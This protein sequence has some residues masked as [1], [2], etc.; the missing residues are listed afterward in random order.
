M[1]ARRRKRRL[2]DPV[3]RYGGALTPSDLR[4]GLWLSAA[5]A[6]VVLGPLVWVQG[7]ILWSISSAAPGTTI[8]SIWVGL[9]GTFGFGVVVSLSAW[10][11]FSWLV[12]RLRARHASRPASP[13]TLVLFTAPP[14]RWPWAVFAVLFLPGVFSCFCFFLTL[15]GYGGSSLSPTTIFASSIFIL[16]LPLLQLWVGVRRLRLVE[17]GRKPTVRAAFGQPVRVFAARCDGERIV[18]SYGDSTTSLCS[19][20]GAEPLKRWRAF[21]AAVEI[22]ELLP[23][24]E[25]PEG[26]FRTRIAAEPTAEGTDEDPISE[27]VPERARRRTHAES[28]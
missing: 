11:S 6:A 15:F 9:L 7:M 26:P 2:H 12:R 21:R 3:G 20:G 4:A 19:W 8:A 13:R 27:P 1:A 10:F 24:A 17:L 16:P 23:R 28:E 14:A 22:R 25:P 5:V 18:I